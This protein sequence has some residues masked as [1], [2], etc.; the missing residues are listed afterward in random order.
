MNGRYGY[1]RGGVVNEKVDD[2]DDHYENGNSELAR[3]ISIDVR[4]MIDSYA[5]AVQIMLESARLLHRCPHWIFA[6]WYRQ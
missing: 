4:G 6:P 1:M 2:V 5:Y 3:V